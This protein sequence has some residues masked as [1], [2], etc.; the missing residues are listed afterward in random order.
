MRQS[1][2]T[3]MQTA[4]S[5][6]EQFSGF[7]IFCGYLNEKFLKLA[8]SMKNIGHRNGPQNFRENSLIASEPFKLSYY[9]NGS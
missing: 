1:S 5:R 2:P 8:K 4:T 6:H 3:R 9:R 7:K